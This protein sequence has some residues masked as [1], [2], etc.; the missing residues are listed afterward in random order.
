MVKALDPRIINEPY[1][2]KDEVVIAMTDD[3]TRAPTPA[4]F[5]FEDH[6]SEAAC[7]EVLF[8]RAR[9]RLLRERVIKPTLSE[10][11]KSKTRKFQQKFIEPNDETTT[12]FVPFVLTAG[13]ALSSSA[14][15]FLRQAMED[16][17]SPTRISEKIQFRNFI[18]R[19]LSTL[20]LRRAYYSSINVSR[21]RC[22]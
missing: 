16:S 8:L 6:S 13:G 4:D 17:G 11:E 12:R 3:A 10:G 5:F 14:S 15:D 2:T 20:L 19:R 7:Q 9:N 21:T 22:D 1:P 18:R